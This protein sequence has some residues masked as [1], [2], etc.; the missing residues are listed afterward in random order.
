MTEKNCDCPPISGDGTFKGL[1]SREEF[2]ARMTIIKAARIK[3]GELRDRGA[4]TPAVYVLGAAIIA[5]YVCPFC[6]ARYKPLPFNWEE[7]IQKQLE[8]DR[9][10]FSTMVPIAE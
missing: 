5:Q 1:M 10:E 9:A 8:A 3:N 4:L 6:L 7:I 2:E